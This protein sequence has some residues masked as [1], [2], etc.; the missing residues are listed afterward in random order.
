MTIHLQM[1]PV[2]HLFKGERRHDP[3]RRGYGSGE[4][5]LFQAVLG[6]LGWEH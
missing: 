2:V 4:G 6:M 3:G 5:G 1:A